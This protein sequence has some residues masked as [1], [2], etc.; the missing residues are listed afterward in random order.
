MG[1]LFFLQALVL[2][3][4]TSKEYKVALAVMEAELKKGEEYVKLHTAEA[5]NQEEI[6]FENETKRPE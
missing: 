5:V 1:K 4:P 2:E 3:Q 6:I